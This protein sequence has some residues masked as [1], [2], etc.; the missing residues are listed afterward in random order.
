V[1]RRRVLD[2]VLIVLLTGSFGVFFVRGVADGLR[3]QRVRLEI[4]V[5]SAPTSD[6]YPVV[7]YQIEP[8]N[9]EP[10]DRL[11]AVE[12]EDLRGSSALRFYDRATRA[13][14]E[15]GAVNVRV[16]RAGTSFATGLELS[17]SKWWWLP[18]PSSAISL[19]VALLI[20]LRAPRWHL[21]RRNLVALWCFWT[22][23][24]L[25]Y[26]FDGP[27]STAFE[28][29][30]AGMLL[31]F[32]GGLL[33]WNV[34]EFTLAARPVPK[35]HR[36]LAVVASL[37]IAA[38]LL[39]HYFLPHTFALDKRVKLAS[40]A[41]WAIAILAGLAR[42]YLRSPALERR[43]VRWVSLGISA[44]V[45]GALLAW[46]TM[47]FA[48]QLLRPILDL[49]TG[50]HLGGVVR[51]LTSLGFPVGIL[52][53]V[54]GYRWL[55]VD[56]VISAAA[57]YTIVGLTVLGSAA[58]VLPRLA[59]EAAPA[60]GVGQEA[61]Q[62]LLTIAL[63]AAAIPAHRFLRPRIDRRIF[64]ERHR[65]TVGFDLLL[66]EIGGYATAPELVRLAAERIDA[67]LGP[68]SIAAYV[69]DEASF[70]P[71]FVRGRAAPAAFEIDS[72]LVSALARRGRPLAADARELDAFDRAALETLRVALVVPTRGPHGVV[73]FTCLGPKLSGDIYT[74][75]EIA[76]LGAVSGRCSE[77]LLRLAD[78]Q[79][80]VAAEQSPQ[81]FRRDGEF[82]TIASAGKEIRL[83]DMRGLHYLATLLS[84]PG[85][86]F[87]ASDLM[88]IGNPASPA[89]TEGD[90]SLTVARGLGDAG[91][92]ID[93]K[94][95]S[96]Y[97]ERLRALD[98]EQAEAERNADLGQLGLL[99]AER[100][101]LLSELEG[102]AR[103]RR[104]A[105]HSERARVAV[106]KAIKAALEKI[107]ERHPELGA[108]LSA[109]IR[110]GYA[111]AYVPDP[112]IQ[113]DWEV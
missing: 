99:S 48:S 54:I 16:S 50:T 94:A 31:F 60:L 71:V 81:V 36:A 28:M 39:L 5:S 64:A 108:H 58:A 103:G 17:R 67:L 62:W 6:S 42:A 78:S 111:C 21:A 18:F 68:V 75:E 30:L 27:A 113:I 101:L 20:L 79:G 96:A 22:S 90:A 92:P 24:L 41:F 77:V 63:V 59:Q 73:A 84:E 56:R 38:T 102:A 37:L 4:G 51:E 7:I 32:G 80:A 55:D 3:T 19:G 95:R 87:Q 109:T 29:I 66:D 10:G 15:R 43:Q 97:R 91:A 106:T 105:S 53:S 107:A 26:N 9:L 86:E 35:L 49:D 57:S 46:P 65:R 47:L 100:E 12:G 104:V 83:R 85:R 112:R 14:R 33:V 98:E 45:L 2:W 1:T 13:A 110:R 34:Q 88:G 61:V 70:V 69:R 23:P 40:L 8:T 74:P 11:E 82:W 72:P 93:A 44:W 76:Q 25:H 89:H 52:V